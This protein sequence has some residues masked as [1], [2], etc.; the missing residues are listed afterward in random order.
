MPN[1][2]LTDLPPELLDQIIAYLPTASSVANLSFASK[3]LQACVDKAGWKTFATTRFPSLCPS[4]PVSYKDASRSLA[5]LSKARDRRAFVSRYIEPDGDITVFPG[6]RRIERWKRPR[7]QTIGFTP[8][9]DVYEQ[10]G[11]KWSD[12]REVLAFS[13]GAELTVRET[14]RGGDAQDE[15]SSW[16]T[17]RPFSAS[18]GK[19]DITTVNL[20]RPPHGHAPDEQGHASE[21]VIIGTANGD[22][23][24][25]SLPSRS[26]TS[27]IKTYFTTQGQPVRSTTLLQSES[28]PRLLAANLGDSRIC[29]YPVDAEHLWKGKVAPSSEIEVFPEIISRGGTSSQRIWSTTLLSPKHLAV[30]LGPSEEPVA[31]YEIREDG[32]CTESIRKFSVQE[33]SVGDGLPPGGTVRK[34]VRTVYPIVP[35]PPQN[36]ASASDGNV[37][38]S[39]GYDGVIRLHDIRSQRDVEQTY[40]DPTDDSA[41]YSLL[42]RGRET[43]I[44]GTS[45]HSLLKFFDL[46]L[47]A[48]CYS[49]MDAT[50]GRHV[51]EQ[52]GAGSN[53][54]W[55]ERPGA[56][57]NLFVNPRNHSYSG[58]G[59]GNNWARRSAE[60]SI[61]SLASPSPHSPYLYAG[62]ENAVAEIAFTA[63]LDKHPDPM[64][65]ALKLPDHVSEQTMLQSHYISPMTFDPSLGL[66][67]ACYS[68]DT[69]MRLMTQ[70]SPVQNAAMAKRRHER[71]GGVLPGL[72]ERWLEAR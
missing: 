5:T 47:G 30:G 45:R 13:A 66:N 18:E 71:I 35:L 24:L 8:H 59:G 28:G 65:P 42:P 48:K 25:L 52:P 27:P 29:L 14:F 50:S 10:S 20:V 56:D 17:Y 53:R 58:H 39:G 11:P 49:Y 15:R 62:V 54:R 31:M 34:L 9:I 67:L 6:G 4:H 19:D 36:S 64:I 51:A 2:T 61:Y 70:R 23:Q 41:V 26:G 69:Q 44:A 57:W 40:A 60:S 72:D 32:L 46:R 7:G 3:S 37:F 22:L 68:Q 38:L 16:M 12:R 55:P 63:L 43:I 1:I 33:K 21:H